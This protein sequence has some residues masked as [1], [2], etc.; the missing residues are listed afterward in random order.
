MSHRSLYVS[1]GRQAGHCF[2]G[3]WAMPGQGIHT[4]C[5]ALNT[6]PRNQVAMKCSV[7]WRPADLVA[8]SVVN[9]RTNM[10]MSRAGR[11]RQSCMGL[12]KSMA[13]QFISWNMLYCSMGVYTILWHHS[14]RSSTARSDAATRRSNDGKL[15]VDSIYTTNMNY[16]KNLRVRSKHAKVSQGR[17]ARSQPWQYY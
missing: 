12:A 9:P 1:C 8:L 11:G 14:C 5:K 13:F 2:L 4:L 17:F 15:H 16:V 7:Q 3:P 10:V 6:T